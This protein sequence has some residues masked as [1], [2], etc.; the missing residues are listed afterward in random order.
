MRQDKI[1]RIRE[2]VDGTGISI[3]TFGT[4]HVPAADDGF[5]AGA[6]GNGKDGPVPGIRKKHGI[7][8]GELWT[9]CAFNLCPDRGFP[10]F[11]VRKR[12]TKGSLTRKSRI[13]KTIKADRSFPD[14][15][16]N[17]FCIIRSYQDF[18]QL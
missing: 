11:L 17:P 14:V 12:G 1:Q 4:V 8:C 15:K 18:Y 5:I 13:G 7:V 3:T 9:G 2:K 10:A 6:C 16:T